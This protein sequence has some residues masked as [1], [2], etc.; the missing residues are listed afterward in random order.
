VQNLV[1]QAMA[2]GNVEQAQDIAFEAIAVIEATV[3]GVG[4]AGG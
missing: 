1:R 2:V 4:N 3:A